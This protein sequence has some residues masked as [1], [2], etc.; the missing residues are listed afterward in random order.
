M[1]T[2]RKFGGINYS[3]NNNITRSFVS[4]SEHLNVST[5]SGQENSKEIFKSHIDM[6]GNSILNVSTLYFID[7][8]ALS[9]GNGIPIVLAIV[10]RVEPTS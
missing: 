5:Y 7:G 9:T 8:S 1:S 2:F 6:S 4:N 3:P 10:F